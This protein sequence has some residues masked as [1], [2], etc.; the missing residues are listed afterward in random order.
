[1]TVPLNYVKSD[2]EHNYSLAN[3]V[4]LCLL[5]IGQKRFH[6]FFF[7]SFS[8]AFLK[9]G[10]LAP[11]Y[12]KIFFT[13]KHLI[14]RKFKVR[15]VPL[16]EDETEYSA[17]IFGNIAKIIFSTLQG[18]LKFVPRHSMVPFCLRTEFLFFLSMQSY[19]IYAGINRYLLC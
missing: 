18:C 19:C 8:V 3:V 2:L 1:M 16:L 9:N 17:L 14:Q 12:K 7:V 5:L 11:D 13:V 10:T 15:Q 6:W 4:L